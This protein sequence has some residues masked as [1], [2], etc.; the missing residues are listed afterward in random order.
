MVGTT[1]SPRAAMVAVAGVTALWLAA[2]RWQIAATQTVIIG[3]AAVGALFVFSLTNR[4]IRQTPAY[5]TYE[6]VI[7][8][9]DYRATGSYSNRESGDP[10]DNNRFRLVWWRAVFDETLRGGPRFWCRFRP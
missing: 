5:A 2:R 7:S 3:I 8:I 6:N 10:G 9:F 1:T 4:D